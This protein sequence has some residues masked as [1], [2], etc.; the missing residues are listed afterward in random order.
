MRQELTCLFVFVRFTI[1]IRHKVTIYLKELVILSEK[2][3]F[4]KHYFR[5]EKV[6]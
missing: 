4:K 5:D 6:A 1:E 2:I 3:L